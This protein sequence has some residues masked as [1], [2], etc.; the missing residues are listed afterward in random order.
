MRKLS[1]TAILPNYNHARYVGDAI[2]SLLDQSQPADELIVIDDGSTDDS[3]AVIERV[4][5]GAP[6]ARLL[7]NPENR[8]V[9]HTLNRGLDE[10]R[11]DYV[12]L[13]A[14]DDW[15]CPDF[16]AASLAALRRHPDAGLSCGNPV[17]LDSATGKRKR[18]PM[19]FGDSEVR[20]SA[21][22]T[23]A[24]MRRSNF[25]FSSC[26][27]LLRR[28]AVLAAGGLIPELRW[29]ADW[30][31]NFVVAFRHG[32]CFVPEDVVVMRVGDTTYSAQRRDWR[33]QRNV[34]RALVRR[35]Y[36]PDYADVLPRFRRAAALPTLQPAALPLLLSDPR[37]RRYVTPLLAWRLALYPI[38]QPLGARVPAGPKWALR[39]LIRV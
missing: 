26:T 36:E 9:I 30:F 7:R 27:A 17:T 38:L 10:A 25:L 31:L 28:D 22:G 12:L 8:G 11:G 4:C 19:P 6:N 1:L 33:K 21:D 15:Y 34:I 3:L 35:L 18:V 37:L 20:F 5:A 13:G 29:H 23:G 39:R 14:A 32:F 24:L 16:F 2:R